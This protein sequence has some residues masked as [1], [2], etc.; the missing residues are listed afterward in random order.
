MADPNYRP[1]IDHSELPRSMEGEGLSI[2]PF[3]TEAGYFGE[4]NVVKITDGTR[5]AL[6]VP[7]KIVK[8]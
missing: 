5:T 3:Y 2:V 1:D 8:P 6:Y 4:A 7:Y